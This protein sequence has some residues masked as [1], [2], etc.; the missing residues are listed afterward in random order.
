MVYA[1]IQTIENYS[2]DWLPN[3]GYHKLNDHERCFVIF[4]YK[5]YMTS[6]RAPLLAKYCGIMEQFVPLILCVLFAVLGRKD[7]FF[8]K[9]S[10]QVSNSNIVY[11]RLQNSKIIPTVLLWMQPWALFLLIKLISNHGNFVKC[12]FLKI[13]WFV[14]V[15]VFAVWTFP[16]PRVLSTIELPQAH[17]NA[18]MPGS[19]KK[20]INKLY[21][22]TH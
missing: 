3:F 7:G 20:E 12:R 5:D 2:F 1:S 16:V 13:S 6:V 18:L 8:L 15:V 10:V 4:A 9:R 21:K 22:T 14:S 11:S 19:P 17:N